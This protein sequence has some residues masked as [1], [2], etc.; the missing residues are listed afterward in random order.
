VLS[1]QRTRSA[2]STQRRSLSFGSGVPSPALMRYLRRMPPSLLRWRESG[3]LLGSLL[4]VIDRHNKPVSQSRA[5]WREIGGKPGAHRGFRAIGKIIAEP[6]PG[7]HGA[8]MVVSQRDRIQR[9]RSRPCR[10]S[11]GAVSRQ[12]RRG[13]E[14]GPDIGREMVFSSMKM[15]P[16]WDWPASAQDLSRGGMV[17]RRR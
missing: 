7:V 1:R 11:S 15:T 17:R 5:G 9:C 14:P 10:S 12:E 8:S 13:R 6:C 16:P 4:Q 2:S 3:N